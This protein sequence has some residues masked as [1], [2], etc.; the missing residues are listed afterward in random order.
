MTGIDRRIF[1]ENLFDSRKFVDP[2]EFARHRM[3]LV[4]K[5]T[6]KDIGES[7]TN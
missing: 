5:T 3:T 7:P 2:N 4:N 6:V 1:R